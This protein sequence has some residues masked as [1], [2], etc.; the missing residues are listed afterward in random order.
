MNCDFLLSYFLSLLF[1]WF[2]C[3]FVIFC[4]DFFLIFLWIIV[5]KIFNIIYL[6]KKNKKPN[7]TMVFYS[8]QLLIYFIWLC[9]FSFLIVIFLWFFV[10]IILGFLFLCEFL[11]FFFRFFVILHLIWISN[12]LIRTFRIDRKCMES[13]RTHEK[14]KN[15]GTNHAVNIRTYFLR[16]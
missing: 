14:T 1:L 11:F 5:F 8:L 12:C 4:F 10:I 2:Y 15:Y 13:A 16:I 9:N 3:T 6:E 7:A